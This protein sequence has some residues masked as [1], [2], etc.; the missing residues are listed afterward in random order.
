LGIGSTAYCTRTKTAHP[1][2]TAPKD[3]TQQHSYIDQADFYD[4][5]LVLCISFN[6][7][8][9]TVEVRKGVSGMAS[10]TH[11]VKLKGVDVEVVCSSYVTG[12]CQSCKSVAIEYPLWF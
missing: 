11:L 10:G 5:I 1:D 8:G 7:S 6:L 2:A 9:L 12:N 4:Q 3:T